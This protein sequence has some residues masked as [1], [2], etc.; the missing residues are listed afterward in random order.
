MYVAANGQP[1][2][3]SSEATHLGLSKGLSLP[4]YL[5]SRLGWLPEVLFKWEPP[6]LT[7][8]FFQTQVLILVK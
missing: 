6:C 4:W 3:H 7:F 1:G 5:P 2:C 8:F